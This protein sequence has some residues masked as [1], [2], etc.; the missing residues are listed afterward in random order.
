MVLSFNRSYKSKQLRK[1]HAK[2]L[3]TSVF[4][5][6]GL[7]GIFDILP[8]AYPFKGFMDIMLSLVLLGIVLLLVQARSIP[9]IIA[10][11]FGGVLPDIIDLGPAIV[12]KL[13]IVDLPVIKVFPWHWPQ[14]SGSIFDNRNVLTSLFCHI[15]VVVILIIVVYLNWGYICESILRRR[16]NKC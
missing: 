12:N 13:N 9:V 3:I 1:T 10:C 4:I 16:D 14:F 15:A 8:H 6:V 11:F 5:N 2:I 7:H